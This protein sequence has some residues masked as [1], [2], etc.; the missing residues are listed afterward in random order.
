MGVT[1]VVRGADHVTNSG[2]QI[3]I[4]AAL[5]GRPPRFAHHSLLTGPEGEA[6]SKRLGTLAL[7]DLREEG[8][9]PVALVAMM[10]RLG[11]SLPVEVITGLQEL[12]DSFDIHDFGL[13]PT[14]FDLEDLR[15]H[16]AKTLRAL[17]YDA[18]APRLT[19]AGVPDAIA[20]DFWA[21]IGPNLDRFAEV[22]DWLALIRK[23]ATP[24]VAEKDREFVA[25]AFDMLQPHPWDSLTWKTW[26]D[27]V[28]TAT[29]RKGRKLYLPLRRA[30]TGR[31]HGPDMGLLMPL[32][33]KP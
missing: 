18:V 24:V 17:D 12:A 30:L 10:A 1:D 27:A 2:A 16:S 15:L 4:F 33:Q 3:Q 9:E 26:T 14:K 32:L 25:V 11:S 6:L 5:G 29:G 13:A 28:K 31:D 19:R 21:A 7:R 20:R 22:D 8:V 23:G